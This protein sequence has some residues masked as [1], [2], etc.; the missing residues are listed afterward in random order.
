MDTNPVMD[1]CSA[2]KVSG[3]IHRCLPLIFAVTL[4]V[5]VLLMR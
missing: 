1:I 2:D 5:I 3:E 4:G